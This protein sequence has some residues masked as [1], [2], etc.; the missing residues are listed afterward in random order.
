M[1][2]IDGVSKRP[3]GTFPIVVTMSAMNAFPIR[4][5][6]VATSEKEIMAL[7]TDE[8][9]TLEKELLGSRSNDSAKNIFELVRQSTDGV[10][11]R[12]KTLGPQR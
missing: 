6:E 12:L 2:S 8:H 7:R 5:A 1:V 9:E 3:E 4:C 11:R 10:Y